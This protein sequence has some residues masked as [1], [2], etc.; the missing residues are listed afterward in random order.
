M[1]SKRKVLKVNKVFVQIF[2][3]LLVLIGCAV[4]AVSFNVLLA[5]NQIASGGVVGLSVI[6]KELFG[7]E[8][9]ITQW[10]LNIP[11][12]ILGLLVL[13]K[14]FGVKTIIATL[15]FP[16][17]ILLTN[18]LEPLTQNPMLACIFG[19]LGVGI[20]L[21]IVFRSKGSTGGFSILAQILQKYWGLSIGNAIMIIDV[22][23]ILTSCFVFSIEKGLY[24]LIALFITG[25]AID[26]VQL[27]FTYSKVA[28]VISEEYEAI[29][30]VILNNLDRG[31]T[32]LPGF[33]G[34][35]GKDQ[36][37]LMVVMASTE[38]V[39]FKAL[40]KDLDPHAFIIISDTNEVLGRGFHL[41]SQSASLPAGQAKRA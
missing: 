20:G 11:L 30:H 41:P 23:V 38:I 32:K 29:S 10:L 16:L 25:K 35:T 8:P 3:M 27:G 14:G 26:F 31:V 5:P 13:G 6:I 1:G 28:F 22:M 18:R 40:V 37:V 17:F 34:Y 4:L 21:G 36:T 33:G 7:L 9:A 39:L 15:T 2:E 24:A 12:F 19:G